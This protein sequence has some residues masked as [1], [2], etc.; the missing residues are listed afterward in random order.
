MA[1]LATVF[2]ERTG[3]RY[4]ANINHLDNLK[5]ILQRGLL[6][7]TMAQRIE[8]RSV[9]LESVQEKRQ[10]KVLF[11]GLALH[12]YASLYIAPRNPMMY[13]LKCHMNVE[14]LYVLM[15]SPEVLD[16]DSV[17]M[18]D[19][20]AASGITRFF[21]AEEGLQRL[22]FD[23]IYAKYWNDQDPYVKEEKA[24]VKCAEVLVP[25]LILPE[26]IV[27]A[28]APSEGTKDHMKK[29]GFD[30]KILVHGDTFFL[31]AR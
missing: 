11:S 13:Y 6:S 25:S 18:T 29:L 19:G 27:G 8:H 16:T 1:N 4:L 28:V 15:V 14:E 26:F 20:N 22:D 9:A 12:D 7:Y 31:E 2:R 3:K 24:R 10:A 17:I 5:S 21:S 30:K 23:Q